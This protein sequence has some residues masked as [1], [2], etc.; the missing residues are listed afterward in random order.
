MVKDNFCNL[1]TIFNIS[2]PIIPSF[3]YHLRHEEGLNVNNEATEKIPS[4]ID[5]SHNT[6]DIPQFLRKWPPST[7]DPYMDWDIPGFT[8]VPNDVFYKFTTVPEKEGKPDTA[9]MPTSSESS[10]VKKEKARHEALVNEN[11]EVGFLFASKPFVQAIANPFI[12]TIS[13]K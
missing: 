13:S 7:K 10:E 3:L 6:D 12:G 5:A 8:V 2:V 9:N 11:F 4:S 1:L